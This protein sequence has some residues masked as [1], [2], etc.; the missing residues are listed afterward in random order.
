MAAN[1][2][3]YLNMHTSAAW[4]NG[5]FGVLYSEEPAA[6]FERERARKDGR[7]LIGALQR[8][9]VAVRWIA[10]HQNG[11]PEGGAARVSAYRGLARSSSATALAGCPGPGP[12]PRAAD[13][14][15]R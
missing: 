8:A 15:A 14:R 13:G 10:I 1:G 6:S 5:Y 3:T 12:S 11:I 9:G 4:T 2:R 7:N